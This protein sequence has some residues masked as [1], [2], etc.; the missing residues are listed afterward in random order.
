MVAL[1]LSHEGF[2]QSIEAVHFA[3]ETKISYNPLFF[4]YKKTFILNIWYET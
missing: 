3:R 4:I 2:N 1:K